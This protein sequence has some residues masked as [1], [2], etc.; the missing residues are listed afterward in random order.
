MFPLQHGSHL[1]QCPQWNKLP[2]HPPPGN[3]LNFNPDQVGK[4]CLLTANCK[5]DQFNNGQNE[6]PSNMNIFLMN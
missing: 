1:P 5:L 3:P 6:R 4:S 2:S